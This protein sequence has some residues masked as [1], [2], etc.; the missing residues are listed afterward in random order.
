MNNKNFLWFLFGAAVGGATATLIARNYYKKKAEEDVQE[1]RDYMHEKGVYESQIKRYSDESEE[2]PP[3]VYGEREATAEEMS[4]VEAFNAS[5]GQKRMKTDYTKFRTEPIEDPEELARIAAL[6]EDEDLKDVP[7]DEKEHPVD[8]HEDEAIR[9]ISEDEFLDEHTTDYGKVE[10][11][12]Y[13]HDDSLCD[14]YDELLPDFQ[15]LV[16]PDALTSFGQEYDPDVVYVRNNKLAN[17]YKIVR[18]HG[19]Y[20]EEVLGIMPDVDADIDPD[21]LEARRRMGD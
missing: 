2:E 16:G 12:Y 21:K 20:S 19:S 9:I 14:N 8:S 7:P 5:R 3:T 13:E 18:I 1:M 15:R 4:A 10:L 17:D 11:T 6:Y